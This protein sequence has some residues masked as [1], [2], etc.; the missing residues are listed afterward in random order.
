M[1]R[2]GDPRLWTIVV[3]VV[4]VALGAVATLGAAFAGWKFG[5]HTSDQ[6][7][8][9]NTV[10]A[11]SSWLLVAVGGVVALCAYLAATGRPDLQHEIRFH[12]SFPDEPVFVADED[13]P[14]GGRPR[15][16]SY[17]QAW[18]TL[19]LRNASL[20]AAKNPGVRIE[21]VGLGGLAEQPGWTVVQM[22]ST[23]GI[24]VIQWDGGA[25]GMIHGRWSRTLPAL[26][27][28]DVLAL[29]DS[30]ALLVTVAADGL[31][32]ATRRL[33]VRILAP[34]DYDAY[35]A[36]RLVRLEAEGIFRSPSDPS[37]S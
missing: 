14:E 5:L 17:K 31:A 30:P 2:T 22:V 26:D 4:T 6:V 35:S 3:T 11:A 18:G 16:K 13:T 25:D 24:T 33:P 12:F 8:V 21:L 19:V 23:V 1:K 10:L 36:E 15:I 7:A 9:V 27:F 28:G 29:A 37:G 20:Y 34:A 32:P